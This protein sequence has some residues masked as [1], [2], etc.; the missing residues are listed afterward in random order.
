M[1][2]NDIIKQIIDVYNERILDLQSSGNI[3]EANKLMQEKTSKVDSLIKNMVEENKSK[4]FLVREPVRRVG[5]DLEQV[6]GKE[7][8]DKIAS[9]VSTQAEKVYDSGNIKKEFS[10]LNKAKGLKSIIPGIGLA[11]GAYEALKSGDVLAATPIGES[12]STG[13]KLGSLEDLFE[14]GKLSRDQKDRFLQ[15]Q[16]EIDRRNSGE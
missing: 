16:S 13:P 2:D 3:P 11:V 7:F 4:K 14:K 15:M 10:I 12:E 6:S 9:R 8:R 5:K 1:S